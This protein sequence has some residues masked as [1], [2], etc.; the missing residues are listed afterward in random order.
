MCAASV[1]PLSAVD[2]LIRS[3]VDISHPR[4]QT[5]LQARLLP[6]ALS[7]TTLSMAFVQVRLGGWKSFAGF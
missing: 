1:R 6:M 7:A 5:L 2:F 4:Q 3:A